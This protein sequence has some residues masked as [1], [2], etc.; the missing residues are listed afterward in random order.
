MHQC[1]F[2]F[3][4]SAKVGNCCFRNCWHRHTYE[5]KWP[6]IQDTPGKSRVKWSIPMVEKND[7][8]PHSATKTR[9]NVAATVLTA[10]SL[11]TP[12][13]ANSACHGHMLSF[14]SSNHNQHH[15]NY[16]HTHT[17][18]TKSICMWIKLQYSTLFEFSM[19]LSGIHSRVRKHLPIYCYHKVIKCHISKGSHYRHTIQSSNLNAKAGSRSAFS[20]SR[21]SLM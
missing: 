21:R 18:I 16:T 13:I 9:A 2:L 11:P 4:L 8:S 1:Y 20:S 19:R 6:Y 15:K 17:H 5:T 7:L 3:I 10:A 12:A 14:M